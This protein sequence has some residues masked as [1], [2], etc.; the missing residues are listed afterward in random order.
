MWYIY[1]SLFLVDFHAFYTTS[2]KL[3]FLWNLT[4]VSLYD[5]IIWT[6][7]YFIRVYSYGRFLQSVF[8]ISYWLN[9]DSSQVCIKLVF[10]LCINLHISHLFCPTTAASQFWFQAELKT[11]FNISIINRILLYL[12]CFLFALYITIRI[13]FKV[14]RQNLCWLLIIRYNIEHSWVWHSAVIPT[15]TIGNINFIFR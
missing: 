7:S 10:V 11:Y 14:F 4:H 2:S 3:I 9:M 6:N 1:L 12:E 13:R 15:T 5:K 8:L